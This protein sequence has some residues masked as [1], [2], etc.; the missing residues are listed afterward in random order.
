MYTDAEIVACGRPDVGSKIDVSYNGEIIEFREV[1]YRLGVGDRQLSIKVHEYGTP[2]V[3]EP[4]HGNL[5]NYVIRIMNEQES[6][7][8]DVEVT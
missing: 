6:R 4:A 8:L 1:V 3:W 7:E 5:S 2:P